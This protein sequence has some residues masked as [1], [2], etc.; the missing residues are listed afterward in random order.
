MASHV[1]QYEETHRLAH[2]RSHG[3]P[4]YSQTEI[5]YQYRCEDHIEHHTAEYAIHGIFG[6]ALKAH[7]VVQREGTRH[8][9]RSH[10]DYAQVS[11][12]VWQNGLRGTEEY[13]DVGKKRQS[14]HGNRQTESHAA[15][16]P[17]GSHVFRL[18]GALCAEHP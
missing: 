18:V 17:C 16:K 5:E 1:E 12:R 3:S 14:H 9:R 10:E 13:A 2:E 11:F 4:C 8:E 7:L 6:V 15:H